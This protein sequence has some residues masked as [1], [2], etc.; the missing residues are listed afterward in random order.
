MQKLAEASNQL[1]TLISGAG[2]ETNITVWAAEQPEVRDVAL[3]FY[4]GFGSAIE[5]NP[6]Y[7]TRKEQAL[8]EHVRLAYS[9]NQL[10]PQLDMKGSYGLNGTGQTPDLAHDEVY[11]AK[12]PSW[13]I[14]VEFRIPVTGGMKE[15]NEYAAAKLSKDKAIVNLKEIEVQ[16][17]NALST[18]LLKVGNLRESVQNHRSVINF[19]EQLLTNQIVRLQ[20]GN[21]D[22]RTVLDTED[23]LFEARVALLENL[24]SYEKSLLELE[25][26][27]GTTLLNRNVDL[28]KAELQEMTSRFLAA[29][30]FNGPHFDELKREVEEEYRN[31][32]KNF[33]ANE[34]RESMM[35]RVF[36]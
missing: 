26:V 4:D 6:D 35:D 1:N 33:D 23:K 8:A 22:S 28:T 5:N 19:H 32:L 31:R 18:A 15:R 2:S 24:V 9:K 30:S 36:H 20:A 13:S 14:G 10:L 7:L 17:G 12:Y 21:I 25:L 3:N 34:K 11:H 29:H 16:I 27:K